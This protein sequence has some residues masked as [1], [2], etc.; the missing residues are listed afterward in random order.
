K[1]QTEDRLKAGPDYGSGLAE[2]DWHDSA[3]SYIVTDELGTPVHPEWYSDEFARI[4]RKAQL[5]KI[6]LHDAR[7]T[8]FSLM[9]KAG[10]PV[11][12]ISKWAGHHDSA[13]TMRAYV[14]ASEEDLEAGAETLARIYELG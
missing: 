1:R 14:H 6:R 5:P 12:V 13:F 8:T 4:L 10:V 3:D 7:H 9:E 2:L 11:S